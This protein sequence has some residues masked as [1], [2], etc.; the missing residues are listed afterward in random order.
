MRKNVCRRGK[1]A[2]ARPGRRL[3]G[4]PRAGLRPDVQ[5][6]GT[7]REGTD[8]TRRTH[9]TSRVDRSFETDTSVVGCYA[10]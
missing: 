6:E 9:T 10:G 4:G 3:A 8:G 1:V 7:E 5:T 2:V